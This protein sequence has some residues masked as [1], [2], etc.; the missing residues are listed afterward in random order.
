MSYQP[1][2]PASGLVGWRFLQRTHDAQLETFA[3]SPSVERE[4]KYF[5]NNIQ[6]V[7]SAED[8]VSDRRLLRVA[9]SAFGLEGDIDNTFFIRKVLEDGTNAD[10]ASAN[11]LSD[12]RYR[13]FSAAFGLGPGD[14]LR[15]G[16]VTEME[17]VARDSLTARFESSVGETDE[18]MRIALYTQHALAD[19]AGKG[20]SEDQKWFELMGLP[21]LRRM[22]E[23]ALG[24]PPA[25]AQ[26]D[27]DRQLDVFKTKLS[28]LTNS[29]DLSQFTESS[30][31]EKLTDT[32][33]ARDQISS[34]NSALSPA[35]TALILLGGAG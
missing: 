17:V 5:L 6:T 13:E 20:G 31:I 28:G 16:L 33:L 23:T 9:L 32:Y 35:R 11:R 14:V 15:T 25:F 22:M 29:S 10:D 3:A 19:L 27:I 21:P 12:R 30:A 34:I 24:L 8:L 7:T 26:L 18:T 2:I 1:V 4:T